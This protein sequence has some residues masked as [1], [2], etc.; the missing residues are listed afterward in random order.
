MTLKHISFYVILLTSIGACSQKNVAG[1]S[2]K[3]TD[4]KIQ[5]IN[6]SD[7]KEKLLNNPVTLIDVRTA[8]EYQAGYIGNAINIGIKNKTDFKAGASRLDKS[9][10]VYL[11]CHSGV[12]SKRA[13]KL[14]K[15][16][17]FDSIY[18]FSGGWK[19]WSKTQN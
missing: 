5:V 15:K 8:E 14:L 3:K 4:R 19:T 17:G 11:Y 18:D 1:K 9:K 2:L 6:L 13:S 12:R 10:P 16:M 7:F